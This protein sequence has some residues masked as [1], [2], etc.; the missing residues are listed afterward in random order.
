MSS[1]TRTNSLATQQSNYSSGMG[2]GMQSQANFSHY[3]VR[4]SRDIGASYD[5][6]NTFRTSN[7]NQNLDTLGMGNEMMQKINDLESGFKSSANM[8]DTFRIL[9]HL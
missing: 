4:L 1:N 2:A 6:N 9:L 7:A 3:N 8:R 5:P